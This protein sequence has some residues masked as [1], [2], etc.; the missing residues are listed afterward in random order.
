MRSFNGHAKEW[1]SMERLYGVAS[2]LY[3]FDATLEM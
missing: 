2:T 3:G 1:D